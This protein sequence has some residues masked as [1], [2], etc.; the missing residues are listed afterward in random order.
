MNSYLAKPDE[1]KREWVLVD[2]TNQIVG[3]LAVTIANILRGRNKPVYTPH[4]DTG[5][6]V[7]VINADKILFTGNKERGKIYYDYTTG[8][9]GAQRMRTAAQIREKNP[10]RLIADA[11]RGMLPK[12][13]LT[14]QQLRK[15][16]VYAGAEHPHAAQQPQPI[17]L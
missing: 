14:R 2:A 4:V 13:R 15:L 5:D 1:V 10:T 11:V 12:N 16:K 8:R 17:K 7:V 9:M 3:R 6:F